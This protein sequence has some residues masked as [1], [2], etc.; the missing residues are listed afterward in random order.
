MRQFPFPGTVLTVL[1]IAFWPLLSHAQCNLQCIQGP[2]NIPLDPSCQAVV[3]AAPLLG[4]GNT[5]LGPFT[6]QVFDANGIPIPGN[7]LN[8]S[9][10][11]DTLVA[12]VTFIGVP[13][14]TCTTTV[15]PID[16]IPPLIVNPCPAQ[17][18]ACNA[19]T[20]AAALP[21]PAFVDN[22]G[23]L[24]I[25]TSDV[26]L[27]GT[28]PVTPW[29]INRTFIATDQGGNSVSCVQSITLNYQNILN[30]TWPGNITLNCG[31]S[32]YN[33]DITGRPMLNGNPLES[34]PFCDFQITFTDSDIQ[35]PLGGTRII[36][37]HWV[38]TSC[39]GTVLEFDQVITVTDTE[40]PVITCPANLTVENT[41]GFC[42]VNMLLPQA[43]ATDTCT[44]I[45]LI[46]ISSGF[47][48]GQ[49]PH[50]IPV[51]NHVITY[52]AFDAL[53]NTASCTMVLTVIDASPPT[54]TCQNLNP[55]LQPS[56]NLTLP[57]SSFIFTQSDNCG[58]VLR[59]V[60]R[61]DGLQPFGP[62]VSFDCA[63]AGNAVPIT[64]RIFDAAGN[65]DSCQAIANIADKTPPIVLE[66]PQNLMLECDDFTG[67]PDDYGM[68][69]FT[70]ACGIASQRDTFIDNRDK[71]GVGL[72][73]RTFEATD[74]SGNISTCSQTLNIINGSPLSEDLIT[75]PEDFTQMGCI[76]S[77][78]LHPDSLQAPYNKPIVDNSVCSIIAI[79]YKD[80]VLVVA[81]P[82]CF[83]ILRTWT[84]VDCC[85]WDP[86]DP[87]SEGIYTHTQ[88]LKVMDNEPPVI[89]CPDFLPVSV[90]PNCT[91]I[92]ANLPDITADDCNPL[93]KITNNSP[94]S[95]SKG[96]NA[97][98]NYPLGSTPVT[99][100][101]NDMCG[102]FSF[103]YTEVV[104][105]DFSPPTP[106]CLHGLTTD[107]GFC[108]GEVVVKIMA[109]FFNHLSYDNCSPQGKLIFSFSSDTSDQ[110]IMYTC[111]NLDTNY[112]EMWVT[113]MEGNQDFCKTY[114]IV[115]DNFDLCP[116]NKPS[117]LQ[118]N[119]VSPEGT[120]LPDINVL[121]SGANN[122]ST[123]TNPSGQFTFNGLEEGKSY[124]VSA[125]KSGDPLMGVSTY[126]LL[127]IQKHLLGVK[128]IKDVHLLLA[129]DVNMSGAIS[130]S[131]IIQLRKWILV[132][133]TDVSPLKSWR[134]LNPATPMNPIDPFSTPNIDL[135]NINPFNA[136]LT[137]VDLMAFKVG[138]I[139]GDAFDQGL[140]QSEVRHADEPLE[141]M[142][143]DV[144]FKAGEEVEWFM[145]AHD[146]QHIQSLQMALAWDPEVLQFAGIQTV[147]NELNMDVSNFGLTQT[148]TGSL[149]LSWHNAY[150]M[151]LPQDAPLFRVRFTSLKTGRL[152]ES[153]RIDSKQMR[154]EAARL[155]LPGMATSDILQDIQL[156]WRE[157]NPQAEDQ[158]VLYQNKPNPFR[159]MTMIGF[160]IPLATEITLSLFTPGG[161]TITE[162]RGK[163]PPGYHEI[164]VPGE[165]LPPNGL[166]FYK[167]EGPGFTETKKM[168]R[169]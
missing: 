125:E 112:V 53:N 99:F 165:L 6:V 65:V 82:A 136:D 10:L 45:V 95:T 31:G 26:I 51:G 46:T 19:D 60:R 52:T 8:S 70:D 157:N 118:G 30:I 130:I 49:G 147:D 153:I 58:I 108:D 21:G 122:M 29:Q 78:F 81:K 123:I 28:C 133:Q 163:Y 61:R 85:I 1:F 164:A 13:I 154:A 135:I 32:P 158:Y 7:V 160:R 126:D 110:T 57:A 113:D 143:N 128:T 12:I 43:T 18:I 155:E 97:S 92:F 16:V 79:G 23:P 33:L 93:V 127:L 17:S 107:I 72:I 145:A 48:I 76:S 90:G 151:D 86:A 146:F 109:E 131:D 75:W 106:Q 56:G 35:P 62:D 44:E 114:I 161:Q 115:Q 100:T 27:S 39:T 14:Q 71:C 9:H 88:L 83:K 64:I 102:N 117:S 121:L 162:F 119:I 150:G 166:I 168:I 67:N 132:P 111:E 139:S 59:Q 140:W 55:T 40:L 20:S 3:Q 50:I 124:Q 156:T 68:A 167:L 74:L 144:L 36:N 134:F 152:S 24:I 63:D 66:C 37:R 101:A 89:D 148:Q 54:V 116:G 141:L 41:P 149:R 22:C 11:Y 138:D 84:V 15:R 120:P 87:N 96:P 98:G 2:V 42:N 77:E 25:T 105:S 142:S 34:G 91:V 129:A 159:D 103:C 104:V 69:T 94:F 137:N 4:P 5:C 73:V 47:G 38:A 169:Q 80:E